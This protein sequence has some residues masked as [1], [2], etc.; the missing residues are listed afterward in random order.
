MSL[1][2][3]LSVYWQKFQGELFPFLEGTVGFL[4]EFASSAGDGSGHDAA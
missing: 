4:T 1:R 2:E 3:T